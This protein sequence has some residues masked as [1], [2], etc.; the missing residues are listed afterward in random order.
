MVLLGSKDQSR[1]AARVFNGT[2]SWNKVL[3]LPR[4]GNPACVPQQ[5]FLSNAYSWL[6]MNECEKAITEES[7]EW[8]K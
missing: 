8:T 5:S 7:N 3:I 2:D 6:C 4:Q 1:D